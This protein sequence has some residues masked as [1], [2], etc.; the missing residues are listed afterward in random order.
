[1]TDA[2]IPSIGGDSDGYIVARLIEFAGGSSGWIQ[3]SASALLADNDARLD[4][5]AVPLNAFGESH[6]SSSFDV[7]IDTGEGFVGG[8]WVARDVTTTVTLS[9][10]TTGQDVY[11][12]WD[13]DATETVII[14]TSGAFASEDPKMKIWTFDTDGSGVTSAT[15]HRSIGQS[16]DLGQAH[17]DDGSTIGR[18]FSDALV[19]S[20]VGTEGSH[21][22]EVFRV[23]GN[24][25]DLIFAIEDGDGKFT[26]TYNAYFDG[27][28]KYVAGGEKAFA[29]QFGAGPGN[30]GVLLRE[31]PSGTADNVITW[32]VELHV[33]DTGWRDGNDTRVYDQ[34]NSEIVQA[35]LGG[36]ASSLSSYPIPAAD[37]DDGSGSGLDADTVD[38]SDASELGS[39]WTKINTKTDS[40]TTTELIMTFQ[41][42]TTYDQYKL[43]IL[44]EMQSSS[45]V[46]EWINV[47]VN[48][49]SSSN[50][51]NMYVDPE[52]EV[53]EDNDT[54]WKY[55][56]NTDS[57]TR[58]Y[59][60][61]I[62]TCV[63]TGS[64]VAAV[65]QNTPTITTQ[66]D[67]AQNMNDKL[68]SGWFDK[69]VAEITRLDVYSGA[70]GS[71]HE[72]TGRVELFGRN[73]T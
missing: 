56:A 12:G 31:A 68:Q 4:Q 1:M 25:S 36:P 58:S 45:F 46:S 19:S 63:K 17:L 35:Q 2:V 20:A 65:N 59:A 39:N 50:Y 71:N 30:D 24:S 66:F 11:V 51:Y 9:S 32:G 48:N 23:G 5:T 73:L 60:E 57:Q 37:I 18:W 47:R 49:D 8:A 55:I 41:P 15:D 67:S 14:G 69:D 61:V 3:E 70:S 22:S 54:W 6:S 52:S 44:H 13:A 42:A 40:D 33:D 34:T 16:S 64:Q 29:L 28:W 21:S 72:A 10:S 27:S 7:T 38:G 43:N 53:D 62:V 26:L